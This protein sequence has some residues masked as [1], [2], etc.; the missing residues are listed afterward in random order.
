MPVRLRVNRRA[1]RLIVRVDP[2]EGA[3][4]IT[5]PS[6]RALP[7]AYAFAASRADWIE[8]Q[9]AKAPRRVPFAPGETIPFRGAAHRLTL[10]PSRRVG[11]RRRSGE[12]PELS[13]GGP[14]EHAP[15]RLEEWLRREAK[16]ALTNRVERHAATLRRRVARMSVRDPQTRWGSCSSAAS[17]SFSWRL[18]MAPPRVLDYVAAH[19]CAH[20]A[21][22]NHGPQFWR[23]VERLIGDPEPAK[24]WLRREGPKLH[25]YGGPANR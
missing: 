17:L 5:A 18:I 1:K 9:L 2:A 22:M 21:H 23:T 4:V 7:Q 6:D 13:I 3:V 24:A 11:V 14:A 12:T 15:R 20:L 25:R 16:A 10:D 19:E 8:D